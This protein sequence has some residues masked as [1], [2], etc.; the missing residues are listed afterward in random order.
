MGNLKMLQTTY[1]L[2][3]NENKGIRLHMSASVRERRLGGL[4]GRENRWKTSYKYK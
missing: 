1:Q 4:A 2:I 3:T